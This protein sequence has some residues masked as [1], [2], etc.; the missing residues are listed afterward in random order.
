[1]RKDQVMSTTNEKI[2]IERIDINDLK[3]DKKP[4]PLHKIVMDDL[5]ELPM[6]HMV[7]V[8]SIRNGDKERAIATLRRDICTFF[9]P[10]DIMKES[11]NNG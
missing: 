10:E 6:N 5:P 2:T 4:R 11:Q 8:D 1:M 9:A 3:L 7:I